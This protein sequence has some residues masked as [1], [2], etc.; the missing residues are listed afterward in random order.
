MKKMPPHSVTVL[1]D[2]RGDCKASKNPSFFGLLRAE[3]ERSILG[4]GVKVVVANDGNVSRKLEKKN[5]KKKKKRVFV[6]LGRG[7]FSKPQVA[8]ASGYQY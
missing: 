4:S 1:W 2:R 5:L 7:T 8:L 6:H 3:S